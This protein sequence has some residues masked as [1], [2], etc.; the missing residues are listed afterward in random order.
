MSGVESIQNLAGAFHGL[1]ER[2][3]S[4]KRSSFDELHHQI[5]RTDVVKLA[6]IGMVQGR[7]RPGLMSE[8]L[9]ELFLG[10]LDGDNAAKPR[11]T[12][13]VYVLSLIHIWRGRRTRSP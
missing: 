1:F 8:A 5:I 9:G 4:L 12:R 13:A 10:N 3:R 6:D 11:V 2:Q 7:Y